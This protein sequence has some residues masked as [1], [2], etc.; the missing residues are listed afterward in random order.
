MFQHSRIV[1]TF[2]AITLCLVMLAGA[3]FQSRSLRDAE[4]RLGTAFITSSW[5]FS[6]LIFEAEGMSSSIALYQNDAL[7][8]EDLR[9]QFDLLWSRVDLV[10]EVKITNMA[11]VEEVI[12]DLQK[13]LIEFDP[14]IFDQIPNS[15][16]LGLLREH[17]DEYVKKLRQTWIGEHS[18]KPFK[19]VMPAAQTIANKRR[20]F[21]HFAAAIALGVLA[22]LL[23]EMVQA[24]K[25]QVREQKLAAKARAASRAKSAFIANVSHEVRT[26]LNGILGM[27]RVLRETELD[28]EQKKC[29]RVLED[30]GGVLLATINDVLDVSKVESGELVLEMRNFDIVPVVNSACALFEEA[31]ATKGLD[32][33]IEMKHDQEFP[34]MQGDERR[35]R[36]VLHNLISNAIKFTDVGCVTVRLSYR[37]PSS[38][39]PDIGLK[40]EV[41][42]T[43]PGIP[44]HAQQQV[45]EPFGQADATINRKHGGTGLGLTISRDIVRHMGGEITLTS[46]EG[47]G[48]CFKILLPLQVAQEESSKSSNTGEGAMDLETFENLSVLVADDNATNRLILRKFLKSVEVKPS[49]AS[50]GTEAVALAAKNKFD[51]ILMDVQMPGMDG[52]EATRR[53][54]EQCRQS[55]QA[56]PI[57]LAVTANALPEQ[58]ETYLEAGIQDVLTKPV[59]KDALIERLTGF[60]GKPF[61]TLED[62]EDHQSAA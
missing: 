55:S 53:I 13:D 20:L 26:P 11:A 12:N 22:Y 62:G 44:L 45:F 24:S 34:T 10:V 27:A 2:V 21:E 3:V 36:Q 41:E 19:E 8:V 37:E 48:A 43:G 32:L 46:I 33:K 61:A 47:S 31:A 35:L 52:V 14:L 5:K 39:T 59:S 23:F 60:F 16:D 54:R 9:L 15:Q 17:L 49:E 7:D 56:P 25:Q 40:I 57:I 51:L 18:T 1:R 50:D 28:D 58:V 38:G 29:L 30:S 6:E 42:D 4:E